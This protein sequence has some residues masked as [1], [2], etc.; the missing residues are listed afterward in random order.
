MQTPNTPNTPKTPE[1]KS[2]W[3]V[4]V[5]MVAIIFMVIISYLV[6]DKSFSG[7]QSTVNVTTEGTKVKP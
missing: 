7:R 1:K 3:F 2:M 4:M 5:I 6:G